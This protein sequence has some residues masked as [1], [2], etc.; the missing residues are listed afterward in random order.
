M[1]EMLNGQIKMHTQDSNALYEKLENHY[2]VMAIKAKWTIYI[3]IK[4]DTVQQFVRCMGGW[5]GWA[6]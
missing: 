4:V 5:R 3:R 1:Q 2:K 6:V